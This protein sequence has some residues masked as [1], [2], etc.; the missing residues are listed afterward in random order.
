MRKPLLI[1][2]TVLSL[3]VTPAALAH[4][5]EGPHPHPLPDAA[6]NPATEEARA[7]APLEAQDDIPHRDSAGVCHVR[8]G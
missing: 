8:H 3:L 6:C 5:S 4:T 7:E 1:A 2:A